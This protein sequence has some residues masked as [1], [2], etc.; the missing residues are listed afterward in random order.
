MQDLLIQ[1]RELRTVMRQFTV[2][3]ESEEDAIEIVRL[4]Q[5]DEDSSTKES[6]LD[7]FVALKR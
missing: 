3:A 7:E 4:E 2:K 1:K 6:P 5:V